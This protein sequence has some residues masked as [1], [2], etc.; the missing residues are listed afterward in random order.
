MLFNTQTLSFTECFY[1]LNSISLIH[2]IQPPGN[3]MLVNIFCPP[4][5]I[6]NAFILSLQCCLD[7]HTKTQGSITKENKI[8]L[9]QFFRCYNLVIS[10]SETVVVTT[11]L[12]FTEND[13]EKVFLPI[14]SL[15]FNSWSSLF[16]ILIVC[17][18][19]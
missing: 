14:T 11:L 13:F 18:L 2:T 3:K 4:P 7:Q 12:V 19:L 10:F 1:Y 8:I 6:R 17:T 5:F 16:S 15:K 9:N